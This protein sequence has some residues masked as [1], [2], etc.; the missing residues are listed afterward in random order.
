ML[1]RT[2]VNFVIKYE[3]ILLHC[4]YGIVWYIHIYNIVLLL[5]QRYEKIIQLKLLLMCAAIILMRDSKRK[6][7]RE[8]NSH[9]VY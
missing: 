9:Y 4:T 2:A 1:S 7:E 3:T 5:H 8:T 6:R